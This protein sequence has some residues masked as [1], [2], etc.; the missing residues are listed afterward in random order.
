M[1]LGLQ[2]PSF[3][4]PGGTPEL[5]PRLVEIAQAAEAAGFDSLW[6][7][8]HLVGRLDLPGWEDRTIG[9][10]ES[11]SLLAA[12]AAV[13]ERVAIGPFVVGVPFRNPALL[14]KM[15]DTVEEISGG[16]LILG[17]SAGWHESE[18]TAFGYPF[19]HRAS[20]FNE[21]FTIIRSLL[22]EGHVDVAG[23]Y[24]TARECELRPRGPRLGGPP[25]LVGAEGERMLR[26]TAEF[27]DAWT[28]E[29]TADPAQLA[30]LCARLDAACTAV[31]RD[32]AT[33]ERVAGVYID[34]P[35]VGAQ[36][37]DWVT[38]LRAQVGPARGSPD[39]LAE[40]LRGYAR[41]GIGH[42]V[43]WPD[44]CTLDSVAALAPV[45][46]HLDHG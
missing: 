29:W 2:L 39:E 37:R 26:L 3:T 40:L 31:G 45:L 32:P 27:A 5:R 11:W 22:R 14:A 16:R 23:Q 36:D 6:V 18:F 19:N 28:S 35:G 15:A 42:V 21:A 4:Y 30:P 24:H 38:D 17:L 7:M 33:L 12:I 44:P 34:L 46:D 25:L 20:R 10:W 8:D 9:F 13:T 43:L 41:I 1:R